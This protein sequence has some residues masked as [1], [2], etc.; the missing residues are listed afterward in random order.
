MNFNDEIWSYLLF[1]I[2][3]MASRIPVPQIIFQDISES[4]Y[5]RLFANTNSNNILGGALTD[6]SIFEKDNYSNL[7]RKSNRAGAGVFSVLSNIAKRSFP[8]LKKY[9][10]PESLNFSAS[11]IEKKKNNPSENISS[12]DVKN[13]AKTSAK[14]I[15][16][17][18]L[19]SGGKRIGSKKRRKKLKPKKLKKKQ[20]IIKIRKTI[21]KGKVNKRK[22]KTNK[23]KYNIFNQL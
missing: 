23:N 20:K 15:A 3:S 21:K 1:I 7:F 8:F 22:T 6:I 10:L 11:L 17:K 4:D 2:K 18:I 16:R 13:L 19:T 12:T 9:I 5:Q 14:N